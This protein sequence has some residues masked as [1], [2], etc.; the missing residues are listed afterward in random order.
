MKLNSAN[1]N[2]CKEKIKFMTRQWK[3]G[4]VE[5]NSQQELTEE[6]KYKN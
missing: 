2:N 3:E 4:R 5:R 1:L 6:G